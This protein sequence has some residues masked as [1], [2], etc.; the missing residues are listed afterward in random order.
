MEQ[1]DILDKPL[2][3]IVILSWN[4][5]HF[6]EKF[7]PSVITTFYLP[8]NYYVIDNASTDGTEEYLNTNF[9][10]IKVIR[11]KENEGFAKGYNIGLEQI[12]ADY[13]VLLNQ[14]VEITPGWIDSMISVMEKNPEAAVCQPKMLSYEEKN[15]FEHAGAAGGY[16][17]NF[18][19]PFCKGRVFSYLEMDDGQYNVNEPV[20]WASGAALCIRSELFFR[21]KGFDE[22]YFAHMEEID[23]CWRLKRCGYQILAVNDAVVYHV[24]GG[25]LSK[26]NPH[27]TY[28]NFRN[29]LSMLFKNLDVIELLWKIPVRIAFFDLLAIV[30]ALLQK[31]W[32]NAWAIIRADWYFIFSIPMQ[33]SKRTRTNHIISNSK[34]AV[35]T[36][37]QK[38]FYPKSIVWAFFIRKKNKFSDLRF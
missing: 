34:I 2:V 37:K 13:F 25:S 27:K 35:S 21:M 17:D 38:G 33:I 7:L 30:N 19:Y 14:D 15:K 8:L 29:N 22:D 11:L 3:A 28:L 6:L 16:L 12:S 31:K 36:V 1:D 5:K 26:E 24:G 32:K 23:L 10:Q 4:G 9:P 18:G 20:F